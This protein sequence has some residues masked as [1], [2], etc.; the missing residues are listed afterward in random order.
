M[1][2]GAAKTILSPAQTLW[3]FFCAW[4]QLVAWCQGAGEYNG[5]PVY[6]T[7][8]CSSSSP[9]HPSYTPGERESSTG[10]DRKI[11]FYDGFLFLIKNVIDHLCGFLL[12]IIGQENV[13]VISR[14]D[15]LYLRLFVWVITP[16]LQP[17]NLTL[18]PTWPT[19]NCGD[20]AI[21]ACENDSTTI[22]PWK[23]HPLENGLFHWT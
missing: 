21:T 6:V 22:F 15:I 8:S 3:L 18:V 19:T 12:Q 13:V 10:R 9:W 20:T 5:L 7:L 4:P 2:Q 16:C 17:T 23:L 1:V 11:F 14:D